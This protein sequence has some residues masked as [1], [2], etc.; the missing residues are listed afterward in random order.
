MEYDGERAIAEVQMNEARTKAMEDA[1]NYKLTGEVPDP[2]WAQPADTNELHGVGVDEAQGMWINGGKQG[3]KKDENIEYPKFTHDL[4]TLVADGPTDLPKGEW[5]EEKLTPA[6]V[7][8]RM[9]ERDV[10]MQ[11]A[12]PAELTIEEVADKLSMTLKEL[13]SGIKLGLYDLDI[14]KISITKFNLGIKEELVYEEDKK[15]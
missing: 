7:E 13:Q 14:L 10:V 11:D 12:E 5:A 9:K 6:E 8:E 15:N 2:N 4:E 3:G 1:L